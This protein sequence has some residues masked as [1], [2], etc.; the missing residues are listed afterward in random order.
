MSERAHLDRTADAKRRE[1][2]IR[3]RGEIVCEC[4]HPTT[5]H[6]GFEWDCAVPGCVC[7]KVKKERGS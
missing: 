4:G 2:V 6:A 7:E 5:T 3:K 1:E